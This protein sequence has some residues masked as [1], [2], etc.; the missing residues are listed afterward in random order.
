MQRLKQLCNF[1]NAKHETMNTEDQLTYLVEDEVFR[2]IDEELG[3]FNLFEAMG[4]VKS[5]L[6]N[7]T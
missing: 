2:S 6:V 5:E 4:A 1:K 3:K 7:A